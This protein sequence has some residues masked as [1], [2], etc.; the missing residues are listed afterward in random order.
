M[1]VIVLVLIGLAGLLATAACSSDPP[2]ANKAPV[3]GSAAYSAQVPN[4]V[5]YDLSL[6]TDTA[7]AHGVRRVFDARARQLAALQTRYAPDTAGRY[8]AQRTVN[9][10]TDAQ[11]QT[12]ITDPAEYR[13]FLARRPE[14]Y[15]GTPFTP[16][17]GR[18]AAA[19]PARPAAA[20]RSA[21]AVAAP[22]R[23]TPVRAAPARAARPAPRK[24]HL[25]LFK[26]HRK[27]RKH[28]HKD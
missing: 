3:K 13:R 24:I 25:G 26:K 28:K 16:G 4:M 5:I 22:R 27:D 20:S 11:L 2:A 19:R 21:P 17:K 18:R 6:T 10:A 14:Y 23:A 7:A 12:I 8:A 1:R 15:A 9:D